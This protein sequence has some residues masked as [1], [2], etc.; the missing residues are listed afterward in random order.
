MLLLNMVLQI[1]NFGLKTPLMEMALVPSFL[2]I[3]EIY[4]QLRVWK[5][6]YKYAWVFISPRQDLNCVFNQKM[7][8]CSTILRSYMI[9]C[10]LL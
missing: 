9:C 1:C 4:D 2:N 3:D 7:E 6:V 5:G 10:V 8:I